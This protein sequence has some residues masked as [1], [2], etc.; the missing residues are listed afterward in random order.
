MKS[1]QHKC[2]TKSYN[3][4][5]NEEKMKK[6]ICSKIKEEKWEFIKLFVLL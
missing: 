1:I 3:I 4:K 2:V 6:L 5:N